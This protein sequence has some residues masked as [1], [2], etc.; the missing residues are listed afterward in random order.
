MALKEVKKHLPAKVLKQI[1]ADQE[2]REENLEA[3]L[4]KSNHCPN[5]SQ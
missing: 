2:A 5:V 4:R 3:L 1:D